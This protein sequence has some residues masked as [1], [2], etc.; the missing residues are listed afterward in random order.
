MSRAFRLLLSVAC[1]CVGAA[2]SSAPPPAPPAPKTYVVYPSPP[3]TPRVQFLLSISSS[4]SFVPEAER[5]VWDAISGAEEEQAGIMEM[6]KPYNATLARGRIYV[7]DLGAN[8]VWRIG[9]RERT[10][11][12]LVPRGYDL[13]RPIDCDADSRDG[14]LY[15]AQL[16]RGH[17]VALAESGDYER[18]YAAEHGETASGVSVIGDSVL[19]AD[20]KAQRVHVFDRMSTRYLGSIPSDTLDSNATLYSPTDVEATPAAIYVSDFGSYK[21]KVFDRQGRFVRSFGTYG[22]SVGQ[23]IRPKGLAVDRDE[24]VYVA[25][26]AFENVQIFNS[27]GQILMY[28][29]GPHTGPGGLM[30]PFGVS[31]VDEGMEFFEDYVSPDYDL[32]YV[33]LVTSQFGPNKLSIFGFIGPGARDDADQP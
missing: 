22:S 23:F 12:E 9:L 26:A 16:D 27:K 20:M 8:A 17:V 25:D 4:A 15:V 32:K 18:V 3:D 5:S 33:I 7:C 30:L 10:F 31:V 21:V 11:E 2:C 19:V 29:G 24:N 6:A 14:T 1:L 28:F 13:S